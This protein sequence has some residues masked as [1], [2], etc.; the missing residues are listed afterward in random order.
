MGHRKSRGG[1]LGALRVTVKCTHRKDRTHINNMYEH[2]GTKQKKSYREENNN[3]NTKR[4]MFIRMKSQFVSVRNVFFFSFFFESS[5]HPRTG[6]S[7]IWSDLSPIHTHD[8][9]LL[10]YC[11]HLKKKKKTIWPIRHSM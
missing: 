1:I 11:C 8:R 9:K 7:S 4:F 3:N 6:F 5:L 10:L 2:N